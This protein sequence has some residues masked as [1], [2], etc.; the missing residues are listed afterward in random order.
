MQTQTPLPPG[1]DSRHLKVKILLPIVISVL[2]V[3]V[4][5]ALFWTDARHG[6][7]GHPRRS[8]SSHDANRSPVGGQDGDRGDG[9][10]RGTNGRGESPVGGGPRPEPRED[11]AGWWYQ[12]KGKSGKQSDEGWWYEKKD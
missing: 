6:K 3:A 2:A 4:F 11:E 7:K 9:N 12:D 1:P 5:L 10:T 8:Q